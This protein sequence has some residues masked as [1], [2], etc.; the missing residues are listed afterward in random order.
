MYGVEARGVGV[1]QAEIDAATA[2]LQGGTTGKEGGADHAAGATKNA[3]TAVAALVAVAQ[4]WAQQIGKV[5]ASNGFAVRCDEGGGLQIQRCC[6]QFAAVVGSVGRQQAWFCRDEGDRV[7]GTN[8]DAT[9]CAGVGIESARAV[10]CQQRASVAGGQCVG[11]RHEF[12]EMAG[13]IALQ[14]DAKERVDDQPP[15][16]ILGDCRQFAATSGQKALPRGGGIGRESGCLAGKDQAHIAEALQQVH[17]RLKTVAT[18]VAG[19]GEDQQRPLAVVQQRAGE[20]GS[21]EAGTLHQR[22]IAGSGFQIAQTGS[23]VEGSVVH[24]SDFSQRSSALP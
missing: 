13:E 15:V 1:D 16:F 10:E 2:K 7:A 19:A 22:L 20:I 23:A 17:A 18:V 14:A 21:G 4:T 5:C 24:V 3:G 11:G 6:L 9:D 8:G 12:G